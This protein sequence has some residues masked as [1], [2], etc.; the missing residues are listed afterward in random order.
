MRCAGCGSRAGADM[1]R[2]ERDGARTGELRGGGN[3]GIAS[4]QR[5]E[6]TGANTGRR[7]EPGSAG[8][9]GEAGAAAVPARP[10]GGAQR[11]SRI[12]RAAAGARWAMLRR[13]RG[14]AAA[15]ALPRRPGEPPEVSAARA[16]NSGLRAAPGSLVGLGT[17]GRRAGPALSFPPSARVPARP[18]WCG[19][20]LAPWRTESSGQAGPSPR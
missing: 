9:F 16:G 4:R 2:G 17:H 20:A 19:L 5:A 7:A 15:A 14:S 6:G 11:C 3:S 1:G 18:E 8:L 12:G 13:A 10:P